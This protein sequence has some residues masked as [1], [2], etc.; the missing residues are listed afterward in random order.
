MSFAVWQ[1]VILNAV[2]QVRPSAN[3]W[4]QFR[5]FMRDLIKIIEDFTQQ[6]LTPLGRRSV[7]AFEALPAASS[8]TP[9]SF[10]GMEV[11]RVLDIGLPL[12]LIGNSENSVEVKATLSANLEGKLQVS[13]T[14]YQSTLAEVHA[15]ALLNALGLPAYFVPRAA[16]KT[17]DLRLLIDHVQVDV[18]V[19]HAEIKAVHEEAR[20]YLSDFI[21]SIRPGDLDYDIALFFVDVNNVLHRTQA[22]DAAMKLKAGEFAT[23]DKYW[24]VATFHDGDEKDFDSRM[25]ALQP[26]WWPESS[27]SF[28]ATGVRTG[29]RPRY[30]YFKSAPPK[31]DY[32]NPLRRKA[33]KF[34][35]TAGVPFLIALESSNLPNVYGKIEYEIAPYWELWDHVSG[36]LAFEPRFWTMGTYKSYMWKLLRNPHAANPLPLSF[37]ASTGD[38]EKLDLYVIESESK[39]E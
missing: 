6:S 39:G 9:N 29:S 1:A 2:G 36:V 24:L 37:P 17:P 8:W 4:I 35:G 33:E 19:A 31:A 3:L 22:F 34:Q 18:E 11:S 25:V 26:P 14:A 15:C 13:D 27:A 28:V 38:K 21:G 20:G 12:S 5:E 30:V 16:H 23:N 32:I 7:A 10:L